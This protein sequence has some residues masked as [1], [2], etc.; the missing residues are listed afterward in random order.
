MVEPDALNELDAILN[1]N[2]ELDDLGAYFQSYAEF[3]QAKQRYEERNFVNF[4]VHKSYK[5]TVGAYTIQTVECYKY[6]SIIFK[7]KYAGQ[8]KDIERVRQTQSYR[9]G[10]ESGF[11]VAYLK[12]GAMGLHHLKIKDFNAVHI[13]GCSED[14]YKSLPRQ[15]RKA[16]EGS[17]EFLKEVIDLNPNFRALQ[18]SVNSRTT[19]GSAILK[20]LY[21]FRDKKSK[22]I[23]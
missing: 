13:H 23:R 19:E 15:R 16:V 2:F 21:N 18:S 17:G 3:E 1:P 8:P 14:A 22:P 5:L 12:C 9:Q 20:D 7:C 6:R 4:S 10:C 11:T